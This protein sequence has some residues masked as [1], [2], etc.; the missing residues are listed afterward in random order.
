MLYFWSILLVAVNAFWLILVPF[1][2]PGNWLMVIT[3]ALF[4]WWQWENGIFSVY[5]LI[6]ITVLALAGEIVEFFAGAGGAKKAGAGWP[7]AIA[8]VFGAVFGAIFGTFVIPLLGTIIG[9]CLGTGLAAAGVE[10]AMGKS[11]DA[12]LRSGLG[13]SMGHLVGSMTKLTIGAAIWLIVAV[14]AF[15]P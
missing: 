15:W 2:L 1:A 5:T 3:T 10:M 7:G 6:G 9:A 14:S 12:S 8:A 11:S 13:A 4:A